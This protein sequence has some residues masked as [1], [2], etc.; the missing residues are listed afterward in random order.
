MEITGVLGTCARQLSRLSAVRA[1]EFS[2]PCW[3]H[4]ATG[5]LRFFLV[6]A[7]CFVGLPAVPRDF[8]TYEPT[9]E[10]LMAHFCPRAKQTVLSNETESR[11]RTSAVGIG[12]T[13]PTLGRWD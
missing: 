3:G 13:S 10:P 12:P 1:P 4:S 7:V 5:T 11:V 2:A 6:F 8:R 9:A